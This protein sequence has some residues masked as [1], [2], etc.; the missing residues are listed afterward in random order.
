MPGPVLDLLH[1]LLGVRDRQ[2]LHRLPIGFLPTPER[3][4]E[5]PKLVEDPAVRFALDVQHTDQAEPLECELGQQPAIVAAGRVGPLMLDLLS[6]FTTLSV[7]LDGTQDPVAVTRIV[8][9][10]PRVDLS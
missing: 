10:H 1:D 7:G 6:D 4:I 3:I 8:E 5:E 2:H 9:V